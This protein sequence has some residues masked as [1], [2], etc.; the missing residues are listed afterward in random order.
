MWALILRYQIAAPPPTPSADPSKPANTEA[1]KKRTNA[2]KLLLNWVNATLPS[3]PA[4][5]FTTDWNDGVRLSALVDYCRPGL[6][7]NHASLDPANSLGNITKAMDVAEKELGVPQ[8]MQPE[9]LAVEKPDELSVMTYVSGFCGPNSAGQRSLK[10]WI[11]SKIPNQPVS[12]LTTD[13]ADG[14]ALA[15]LV[16]A[17]TQGGF[18][19]SD[20]MKE[21]DGY[22]N[23]Q[24]AMEAA[25]RLLGGIKRTV[26]PAE[27]AENDMDH[28]TRSTYLSQFRFAE[29]PSTPSVVST[30]KAVG[31]GITGDSAEKETNFVLRGPRIPQW[32]KIDAIVRSS[33]GTEIPLKQKRTSSKAIQ[34]NY[35]PEEAGEYTIE[36]TLNDE[37]VPGSAFNVTH[38]P[39]TRVE[40][41]VANGSGL[42]KAR[43][44]ETA[45]FSVNCEQGGP[46]VLQVDVEG[47][48]GNV[49]VEVDEAEK[50]NYNVDF[51]PLETGDHSVSVLWDSKNIPSSPFTCVVTDPKKCTAT[52]SGLNRGCLGDD[53]A[54]AVKTDK[55]GPGELV[56]E[57]HGPNGASVPVSVKDNGRGGYDVSYTPKDAGLHT[58][59][60]LWSGAPISG[61]PFTVNIAVPAD[62]SK[63]RVGKLPE[64]RLRA[65]H[66]Y[67]FDVDASNAGSGDMKA[68]AQ[69][70]TVPESCSVKDNGDRLYAVDF[71]PAEVG[72]LRVEVAYGDEPIPESPFTFTV[73]D[74]TKVKVNRAAIENGEYLVQQPIQFAVSASRAGEGDI[75]ATIRNPNGEDEINIA[76]QGGRS[77][78]LDY[79]PKEGGSHA[80]N[81]TFDGSEIP[82]VPIRVFVDDSNR[83]DRVVVTGPIPGKIGAFV[84]N[85]PYEYKVIAVN[86]GVEDNLTVTCVGARTGLKPSVAVKSAGKDQFSAAIT[87]DKPDRYTVNIQWGGEHVPGSPFKL[88][89]EGIP[90]ADRV[91]CVGPR[92]TVGS[93]EPVTLEA[94]AGDAGAGKLSAMCVGDMLGSIEVDVSEHAPRKYLVSFS[95]PEQDVFA[96]S[97]LWQLDNVKESPFKVNIIAPDALKCV[98]SGPEVPLNPSEPIVLYV[99]ASK[100]GNGK[101]TVSAM[102]DSSGEQEVDVKETEENKFV[103]SFVPEPTEFYTWNVKWGDR[104]VPGSPFK[105]NSVAANADKV[106][107]CEPPTAMLEAGQPIGICFDTSRGG[108]GK[109]TATCKGNRI[110]AIPITLH[111]R[112]TDKHKYDVRFHPREPDIFVVGVL[113]GGANVK[114]SPFTINLMPID[115]TKVKVI[116]PNM[117]HGPEGPID[118]MLQVAGAGS[119]KVT[120][121]CEGKKSGPVEV[122]IKETSTDVYELLFIPPQ[123]DRYTF[124][125][126]YG[127]QTVKGSPFTVNT[128]PADASSIKVTEP[129]AIDVSM[130]V[131]YKV[132][133]AQAG[134]GKLSTFCRGEKSGP[135]QLETSSEALGQ[136]N[137][138]FI[139]H[140]AELYGVSMDWSGV[141]VPGSPFKI[142]LR[143]PMANRVKVGELHVP[144][145]AGSG[146]HVWIDLNCLDAGHGPLK[147]EVKGD[148]VG[149]LPIEADRLS[150]ANYRMKFLPPKPDVYN[151]AVAYGDTQVMGSPFI[152]NL[153]LPEADKVNLKRTTLPEFEGGPVSIYFDT[154]EAGKGEMSADVTCTSDVTSSVTKKVEKLSPSEHKVAFIPE[155]PDIY[156]VD[157]KWSG[158]PV[159]GSPFKV[160]TRPPLHPELVRCDKPVYTDINCPVN[161]A[162]DTSRAGPGQVTA[163]CRDSEKREIPVIVKKPSSPND[164]Y[165][166]SFVPEYD[167]NFDLSVFFEGD[168][169]EGSPFPVN[170]KPVLEMD[171]MVIIEPV[172]ST[173]NIDFE[174]YSTEP[175]PPFEPNELT[176]YIGDPL[177]MA[178][179]ADDKEQRRGKL[180]A[181]ARGDETGPT[182]VD[183]T[184]NGDGT[185]AVLF[186]PTLVDRYTIDVSL[187]GL[188][189][190]GSPFVVKYLNPVNPAK[191][192]I[193]GLQNVPAVPEV[194]E[195]IEFG[196]DTRDA[197]DGKLSVTSDGPSV[198]GASSKLVVKESDKEP[199]IYNISYV[200]TAMGEHRV[201]LLWSGDK[202]PGTPL[203]FKIG[204]IHKMQRYPYGKPVTIDINADSN[205]A[206]DFEVYAIQEATGTKSK[207][208][209]TKEKKG[210]F[211]LGFQPKQPGIYAVHVLMKKNETPGSPYRIR[212]LGPPNP[213]GVVVKDFTGNGY[214]GVPIEFLINAEEAGTGNLGVRVEGPKNISDS[215]ISYS[216]CPKSKE[217]SYNV[218]YTPRN[219]GDH[220]FHITWAKTPIP[221]TP[222]SAD[223]KDLKPEFLTALL[224]E[225]TNVVAIGTP[226]RVRIQN[227][228]PSLLDTISAQCDGTETANVDVGIR[229]EEGDEGE[230]TV[231]FI[232]EIPDDY[233]LR[234]EANGEEITG[235]PFAI[236]AI[237]EE[238]LSLDYVYS[239]GTQQSD[240]DA[241]KPVNM[242][243]KAPPGVVDASDVG[244]TVEG[245]YGSCP[246]AVVSDA[247]GLVGVRFLPPLSGEYRVQADNLPGC[248]CKIRAIGKDPDASNVSIFDKDKGIFDAPIPFGMPARFRISTVDAGPGTLNI[249]SKGP[250]KAKVKVLDNKDG[251]Y[252]CD[253]KP[254]I[255]GK[256][257]IDILWNDSHINGSP[258]LL[259]F[260]SK[261]SRVIAGLSLENEDFRIDV[262]HR[263]KLHCGE[264]GE[265]VLEIS[266]K[267][268]SAAAIRLAP[269]PGKNNSYQCEIL[270]KEVGNHEVRV[271]YNGKHIFGSPFNVQFD[272]RGD[273]SK[274]RM[275]ESTISG[276][277]GEQER[278]NFV[279]ST[280]GAGKG[281]LMS[282]IEQTST[283]KP[284]P[285]AV[286]PV[287][288]NGDHFKVAFHPEEEVEYLLTIKYDNEHILG[289]PFKLMFGGDAADATQCTADG[290]G[291]QACI[292]D[293]EAKFVVN[294][295]KPNQGELSV[296]IKGAEGN[297]SVTPKMSPL[298]STET[299]VTYVAEATGTYNLSVKWAN[300]EISDSPFRVEC[301]GP[302]DPGLW[303][304]ESPPTEVILG[305]PLTFVVQATAG[306]PSDDGTLTAVAQSAS[307]KSTS[308]RVEK[309]DDGLSYACTF[310]ELPESG[311]YL[312]HVRWNGSHVQKS[313]FKLKVVAP[314]SPEKV[315]AYGAGL[316]DGSIG[317]EGNFTVETE[318][319]GA[320]TL[321]VRVHGPK[322][323]FK[324]NMRRHPDNDRT[325]LVRYDPNHVGKYTIDITWSEVHIPGSPFEVN[326]AEQ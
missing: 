244:V 145:L 313:P 248:P 192:K 304:V 58:V 294:T 112:S 78:L 102:G 95:P 26:S 36:I 50:K 254:T 246:P 293:R 51:T 263:F 317:Q 204:D 196:V 94:D 197:G 289:S 42:S 5:N 259:H 169:I 325:I 167:G 162:V 90:Q 79:S 208:K 214:V 173:L 13:W 326:F 177:S 267:P 203:V 272:C 156:N 144:D 222:L 19:E 269:L 303:V 258:Y 20:Q 230:Y 140:Q 44:G 53:M 211:K 52:G 67:S 27:F 125:V 122:V 25:E 256:Y 137:I 64:G 76:D 155:E 85:V 142:D 6:L 61:S 187:D 315:R 223:V 182:D 146:E 185:F 193:F 245:P 309:S 153:S 132:D 251:S 276:E 98:V 229:K 321:A 16:D 56:V 15:A 282:S 81:I 170:L 148:S 83:A 38:V 284:I 133:T 191:C 283:K 165:D 131:T 28:L 311:K 307:N 80:I 218:R 163:T 172:E 249:T 139:P 14:R 114:G 308:G 277:E 224:G 161:L 109:L 108:K 3:N 175:E 239:P 143:P 113:W 281:K 285:V 312:M 63:C 220:N 305:T 217:L 205:K 74:P 43:V 234:I 228:G 287:P 150:R 306:E 301:Y 40:G 65:N 72:P 117:A 318:A 290:D 71:S 1:Q 30:L 280:E 235:S 180:M 270:P 152:V 241:G 92:Y 10:D 316:L 39:P 166:V 262:P 322:G 310:D 298:G 68:S 103:L 123:P 232:P 240:V 183:I 41:C 288:E 206:G 233:T 136:Y 186:N 274:C 266:T 221:A 7:P 86:A 87:A 237:P 194:N 88:N 96:L 212:Y 236:K 268:P 99:D 24:E 48:N 151:F 160:D 174:P 46:G 253:F 265:G 34:F 159:A 9:D 104:D 77:Y 12:N 164:Q 55:G 188:P 100:A 49:P 257:Q 286:T 17:L 227:G 147:G 105:V 295:L 181:R 126:Q 66:A 121:T 115:V 54:F 110:G 84:V 69:G 120:G 8:V 111:Q 124:F 157:V 33:D 275:V 199:G 190:P 2:K 18:P 297:G 226:A 238:R 134:M 171:E 271:Q 198:E 300:Q 189:I 176:M 135:V 184:K 37:P 296:T 168:E 250:G 216:R 319:G 302:S 195:P 4:R 138:S 255:A 273:A 60:L 291:V 70:P 97:I 320:G 93:L 57:V 209:V 231:Q 261:K 323:A 127:G 59:D 35:T 279:I 29:L 82:D 260:K 21:G 154:S 201:H 73:N 225:G 101:L 89:V 23:C 202:I 32:A 106:M 91:V 278:V 128:L 119:G 116:G 299:E 11:N 247:D 314:P 324:I 75:K 264:V 22:K 219:P 292:L 130:L 141:E 107:I 242:V 210:A 149:R 179:S 31:P 215:D 207:V 200:P 252:T 213:Q 178:V 129:D 45:G 158:K 62:A 118:L 47:P 243:C